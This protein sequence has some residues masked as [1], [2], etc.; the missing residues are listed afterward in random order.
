VFDVG[1]EPPLVLKTVLSRYG[2]QAQDRIAPMSWSPSAHSKIRPLRVQP[3]ELSYQL[4][5]LRGNGVTAH[6][7]KKTIRAWLKSLREL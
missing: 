5:H 7:A 2:H 3:R 1:F 6:G 4:S